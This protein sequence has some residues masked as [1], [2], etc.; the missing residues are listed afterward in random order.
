MQAQFLN[1]PQLRLWQ[2]SQLRAINQ[3]ALVRKFCRQPN[4]LGVEQNLQAVKT[5]VDLL[6]IGGVHLPRVNRRWEISN[7]KTEA[8]HYDERHL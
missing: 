6:Q 7:L 3:R 1:L 4:L 5:A 2:S 8:S